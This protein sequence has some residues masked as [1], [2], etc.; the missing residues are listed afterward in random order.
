VQPQKELNLL[1]RTVIETPQSG[2]IGA[3][4]IALM[5]RE[6]TGCFFELYDVAVPL[7]TLQSIQTPRIIRFL[8][9]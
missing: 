2:H 8:S 9:I 1:W 6:Q 3:I 4:A 5:C 7:Q